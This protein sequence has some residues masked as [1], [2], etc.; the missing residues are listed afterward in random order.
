MN[1]VSPMTVGILCRLLMSLLKEPH[2][3]RF[4]AIMAG[5]PR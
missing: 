3:H 1:P 2:R 4:N 5:T